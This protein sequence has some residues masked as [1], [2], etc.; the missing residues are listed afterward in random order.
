MGRTLVFFL[1]SVSLTHAQLLK[2]KNRISPSYEN[3]T[4]CF[5]A[6]ESKDLQNNL[7]LAP[8]KEKIDQVFPNLQSLE[9]SKMWILRNPKGGRTRITLTSTPKDKIV[10]Q[11]LRVENLDKNDVGEEVEI[12]LAH[13][14]QASQKIANSYL[15][16][17]E[18]LQETTEKIDTKLNG[19]KNLTRYDRKGLIWLELQDSRSGKKLQ[20]ELKDKLG[21]ICLCQKK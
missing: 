6:L 13:R 7:Q 19:L 16:R 9:A 21:V 14:T 20:C 1:F 4:Q 11:A 5:S 18:I 17:N 15:Y 3:V 10:Q 2:N 8:L 12:P